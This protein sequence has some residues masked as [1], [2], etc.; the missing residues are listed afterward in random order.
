M[1]QA[2]KD[3]SMEKTAKRGMDA[4]KRLGDLA[5]HDLHDIVSKPDIDHGLTDIRA[6]ISVWKG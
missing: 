1:A 3:F 6:A 2:K 5:A 4:I